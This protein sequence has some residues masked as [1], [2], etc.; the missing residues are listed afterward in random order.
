[1]WYTIWAICFLAICSY[2]DIR[3]KKVYI[4]FCVANIAAA[5]IIQ[6]TVGTISWLNVLVGII[7]G[8]IIAIV[9][10]VTKEKI[11]KGDALIVIA[12]GII[13]GGQMTIAILW[14]GLI[15]CTV[16]SAVGLVMKKLTMKYELPLVPFLLIGNIIAVAINRGAIA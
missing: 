2:T 10:I 9:A 15:L 12:I 11:G 4:W 7:I 13:E 1:M 3:E 8:L 6:I 14:W 16:V 5:A